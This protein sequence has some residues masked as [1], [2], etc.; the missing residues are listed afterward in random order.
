MRNVYQLTIP[1][2]FHVGDVHMYLIVDEAISLIDAGVKTEEAWETLKTQLSDLGFQTSDIDQIFLTHHHPDHIGLVEKFPQATLLAHP[3]VDVW[4]RQDKQFLTKY[5]HYYKKMLHET[6]VP[7]ALHHK[8]D[9]LKNLL[10]FSGRGK[11]MKTLQDGDQLPGHEKWRVIETKGHAQS[12]ISFFREEDGL[13]IGGDHLLYNMSPNPIIEPPY[14][15]EKERSKPLLQYRQNLKKCA[16]LNIKTVL[17]GHGKTFSHVNEYVDKQLQE[18]E[19]RAKRVLQMLK[20]KKL[21]PFEISKKLFPR[22]YESQLQLTMSE[23]IGQLDYLLAYEKVSQ[24]AIN[25]V[26]YFQKK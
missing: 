22:H 20:Q 12:H 4:L 25:G 3:N 7:K 9:D 21:T 24:E 8:I 17:P 13:F 15:D 10:Y 26:Q 6:G 19:K 5:I 1:T 11:L 18:Q 14:T 23:A 16:S 2:P